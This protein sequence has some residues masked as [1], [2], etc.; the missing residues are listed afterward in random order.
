MAAKPHDVR[1]SWLQCS[2]QG[3]LSLLLDLAQ[4]LAGLP[5]LVARLDL[6]RCILLLRIIRVF[7]LRRVVRVTFAGI[8]FVLLSLGLFLWEKIFGKQ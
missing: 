6:H 8:L 5:A 7:G 1:Q 4:L 2:I 3:R